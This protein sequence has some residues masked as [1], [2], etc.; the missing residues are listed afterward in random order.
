M[1]GFF[2]MIFGHR[3]HSCFVLILCI[4]LCNFVYPEVWERADS[5]AS[6]DSL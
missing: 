2:W 4:M 6:R 3:D 1:S 5:T